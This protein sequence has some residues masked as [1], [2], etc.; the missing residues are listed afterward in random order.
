MTG[1]GCVEESGFNK[2]RGERKNTGIA[3]RY[4]TGS[5]TPRDVWIT[6][7]SQTGCRFYDRFGTMQPGKAL[8][9][10][11]GTFGPVPAK[12]R[13]WENH[14]NGVQFEEPLHESVFEHICE[15]LSETVP[16]G[17]ETGDE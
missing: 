3:G 13:W 4:R 2:R 1:R 15:N 11:I 7:L 10:R 8:T 9:L 6:D 12:V 14:T 17:L 16:D 5:G